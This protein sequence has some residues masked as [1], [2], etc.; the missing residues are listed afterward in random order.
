[1]NYMLYFIEYKYELYWIKIIYTMGNFLFIFWSIFYFVW[2]VLFWKWEIYL[3]YFWECGFFGK[4][5]VIKVGLVIIRGVHCLLN[6]NIEIE[7]GCK[8]PT[9]KNPKNRHPNPKKSPKN[10]P[11]SKSNITL[12][13]SACPIHSLFLS[14]KSH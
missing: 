7:Y 13:S 4:V 6:D 10:I 12:A 1:M 5:V 2:L 11:P 9:P 8:F 3:G 14:I